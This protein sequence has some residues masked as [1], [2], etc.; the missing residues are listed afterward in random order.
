MTGTVEIELTQGQVSLVDAELAH[1]VNQHKWCAHWNNRTKSFYAVRTDYSGYKPKTVYMHLF[2]WE[3]VNGTIPEGK[4][5]DHIN[6]TTL[7]NH[8]GNLRVVNNRQQA[9]NRRNR[10]EGKT[11]SKY[12]GVSWHNGTK[13]W[14]ARIRV[15]GSLIHIGLFDSEEEAGIAYQSTADD[16]A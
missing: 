13:K 11:S 6:G 8:V 10:R 5:I 15:N 16:L 7:D 14:E 9:I 12:P 3:Y 4:E 2:I 1:I